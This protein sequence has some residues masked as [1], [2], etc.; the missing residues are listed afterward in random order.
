QQQVEDVLSFVVA[1]QLSR[2]FL[3]IRNLVLLYQCQ[4]VPL[5]KARQGGF[6]EVRIAGKKIVRLGIQVGEVT[7]TAAGHEN[8]LADLVSMIND[9]NLAAPSASNSRAHQ[10]G[11]AGADNQYICFAGYGHGSH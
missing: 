2:L 9:H 8:L 11:S 10:A 5:G 3:V 6:A 7:P 4:K 1:E